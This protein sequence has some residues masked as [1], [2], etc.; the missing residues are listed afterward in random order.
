MNCMKCGRELK[1]SAVF[2][3]DCAAEMEK[4]PVKP[5]TPVNLPPRTF[6]PPAKKKNRRRALKPEEQ[7]ARLR[8]SVRWLSL[9]LVVV[10][11]AFVLVTVMLLQVL[12]QRDRA[13][14][15]LSAG[16]CERI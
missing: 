5:G 2:C 8:H 4:Y 3:P 6:S 15:F 9:A 16:Y 10:I 14:E 7:A 11:I 12:E 1:D 13:S